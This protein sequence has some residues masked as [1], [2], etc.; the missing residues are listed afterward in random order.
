MIAKLHHVKGNIL[1]SF[2]FFDP[3][4]KLWTYCNNKDSVCFGA[5]SRFMGRIDKVIPA[6][7]DTKQ[8]V[9]KSSN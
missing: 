1:F 4:D 9:V 7:I 8:M 2:R 5:A 3:I 6:I